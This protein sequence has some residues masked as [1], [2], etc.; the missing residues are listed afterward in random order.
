MTQ[1]KSKA[2]LPKFVAGNCGGCIRFREGKHPDCRECLRVS[3]S[4]N[5]RPKWRQGEES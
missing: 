1:P 4:S 2:K 3:C 5:P